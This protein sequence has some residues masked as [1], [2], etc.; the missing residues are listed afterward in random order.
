MS[1]RGV[2]ILGEG[3]HELGSELDTAL[4][5]PDLPALPQLIHRLLG[6][7]K[8]T[9]YTCRAFKAVRPFHGRGGKFTKK[10]AAAV[11]R[12][13][14]EGFAAVAVVIDRDRK[15]DAERIA[16]LRQGRDLADRPDYPPC[17][18]GTAIETFDAW[19]IVDGT[20]VK[21][22][23]GNPESCHPSPETL[24]GEARNREASERLGEAHSGWR[25]AGGQVRGG[26]KHRPPGAAGEALPRGL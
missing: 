13:R 3:R 23:G 19:M 7:P 16:A 24:N 11:R 6:K 20:A 10:T 14:R 26:G 12:A 15:T 22:A 1:E 9:S 8:H 25:R 17:A 21:A 2:L 18:V 4:Q 5:A